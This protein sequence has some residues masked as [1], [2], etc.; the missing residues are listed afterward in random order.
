MRSDPGP[1]ISRPGSMFPGRAPMCSGRL[2]QADRPRPR[3]FRTRSDVLRSGCDAQRSRRDHFRP[4]LDV[5]G[6]S[7]DVLRAPRPGRSARS[8][9][10]PGLVRCSS[11]PVRCAAIQARSLPARTRCFRSL[12]PMD[13]GRLGG[14][15]RPGPQVLRAWSRC[16]SIRVRVMRSDPGGITSGPDSM[17][18]EPAPMDLGRLG[19]AH[20]PGP[21]VLRAWSDV[22]R[23]GCDAQR[24]RRGS[25]PARTRCFRSLPLMDLGRL[26]RAHRPGPQVL[27]AWSDVLRSRCDAQRSRRDHFRPDLDVSGARLDVLRAPR[28]THRPRTPVLPAR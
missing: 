22:L 14:A 24:S 9:G 19:R 12:P 20:R 3:V 25:L 15:H 2:G 13:L 4:G 28:P 27:R 26:G 23:S 5:S 16:S 10:T 1:I 6:A 8:P 18:P 21:Q 7:A 11:I 17:F